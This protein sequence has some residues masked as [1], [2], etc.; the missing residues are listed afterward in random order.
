MTVL[1]RVRRRVAREVSQAWLRGA[2]IFQRPAQLG[3]M[4][5]RCGQRFASRMQIDDLKRVLP[6]LGFNYT[7]PG[8]AGNWQELC[9]ACKR[10]S[11]SAAQMRMREQLYGDLL[12][13]A[14]S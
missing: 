9:P 12:R 4:C 3:V 1:Q 14:R 11:L 7:V 2:Y 13:G 6:Q 10:K 5:A 8:P